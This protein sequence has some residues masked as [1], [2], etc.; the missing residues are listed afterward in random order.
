[1]PDYDAI[2]QMTILNPAPS[3]SPERFQA[4]QFKEYLDFR[5]VYMTEPISILRLMANRDV[6]IYGELILEG[7]AAIRTWKT[8]TINCLDK[9]KDILSLRS[10]QSWGD[11]IYRFG[12]DGE[13]SIKG[14]S[15]GLSFTTAISQS[16]RR[17]SE[18]QFPPAI[19]TS[20][21]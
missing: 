6:H 10:S 19:V 4:Y 14:D 20:R 1:M 9:D 18:S 7:D 15:P 12:K 16:S 17:N 2:D 11:E 3:G 13:I 8:M 21:G 5:A